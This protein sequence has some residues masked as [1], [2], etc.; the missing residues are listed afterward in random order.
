MSD[1]QKLVGVTKS[2]IESYIKELSYKDI[3]PNVIDRLRITLLEQGNTSEKQIRQALF[4][5][6]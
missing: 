3:D 5:S 2:V 4:G 1:E 6:E